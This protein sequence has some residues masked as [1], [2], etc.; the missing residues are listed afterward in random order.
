MTYRRFLVVQDRTRE[1]RY[2]KNK[3]IY[4]NILVITTPTSTISGLKSGAD[5]RVGNRKNKYNK[6]DNSNS[7][8]VH[9]QW[10]R[11]GTRSSSGYHSNDN[12]NDNRDIF[13]NINGDRSG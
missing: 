9:N 12:Q 3:V 10:N 6:D 1:S 8:K 13:R 5:Q 2:I 4:K 11:A 7:S